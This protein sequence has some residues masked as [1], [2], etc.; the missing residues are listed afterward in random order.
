MKPSDPWTRL[1]AAAGDDLR[2]A[3][4]QLHWAAQ[5]LAAAGQTFAKPQEDDSHRAMTWDPKRR[6]LVSAAFGEGYPF[7]VALRPVDLTL[8]LLDRTEEPLG[9]LPLAG[10]TMADAYEWLQS[11]LANYMGRLS[12]IDKP[13]W[14]MPEH[15]VGHGAP[16]SA[17]MEAELS[18][19]AALYESSAGMLHLLADTHPDAAPVRCWPHHFDI[20]TLIAVEADDSGA[21]T[22]T[23]GVGMAPMGGGY[24]GWYW[25]VSPW[26]Y[27]DAEGLPQLEGPGAWHTAGWVGAV[28]TGQE[29]VDAD[30]AFREAVVKKFI[31]Y[32]VATSVQLLQGG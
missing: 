5:V 32:S 7:R 26:P 16:F 17:D 20:A 11:G 13:E 2:D 1:T 19:L 8:Q 21:A 29:V 31:D 24:D 4:L 28:L 12:Q 6:E 18:V 3:T 27:P 10:K 30:E 9:S 22:K 14:E 23:V 15:A 25:Y